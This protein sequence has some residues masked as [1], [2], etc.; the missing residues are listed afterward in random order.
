MYSDVIPLHN[1]DLILLS[2]NG[3]AAEGLVIQ[4]N[5]PYLLQCPVS[6]PSMDIASPGLLGAAVWSWADGFSGKRL[7]GL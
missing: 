7:C 3:P 5:L 4:E 1:D 2:D 6:I